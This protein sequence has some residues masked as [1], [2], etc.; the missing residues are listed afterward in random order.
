MRVV[1][2]TARGRKLRA[3]EGQGTRPITDRAKEGIFNMLGS[4]GGVEGLVVADLWAGSGSFGIESL[5]RGAERAI[6]V[7]RGRE[8]LACLRDNLATLGFEDRATVITGSLPGI[9][10]GMEPVDIAFCDPP[11]AD[12]PWADLLD[13]VPADLVVGHAEREVPLPDG[14]E[15]LRRRDYGRARIVIAKRATDSDI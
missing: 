15:E 4:L 10:T 11:Y 9:L 3:P 8:A 2:G 12:D 13:L 7:E 6:F 5:S 14:W 1:S